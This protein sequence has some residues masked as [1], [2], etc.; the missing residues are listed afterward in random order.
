MNRC[1]WTSLIELNRQVITTLRKWWTIKSSIR[2]STKRRWLSISIREMSLAKR[3]LK[4][5]LSKDWGRSRNRF[6]RLEEIVS[7][8]RK[9]RSMTHFKIR[10]QTRPKINAS[11][12]PLDLMTAL[13]RRG[14]KSV[15][16]K[17]WGVLGNLASHL[18]WSVWTAQIKISNIARNTGTWKQLLCQLAQLLRK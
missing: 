8:L 12:R 7:K 17:I 5:R 2:D 18:R 11:V 3:R 10:T 9:K 13:A 14:L 16:D 15:R 1:L 4:I 6:R